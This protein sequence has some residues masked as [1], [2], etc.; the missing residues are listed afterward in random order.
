M[1]ADVARN[2]VLSR[3]VPVLEL[4]PQGPS[5]NASSVN[6]SQRSWGT[7]VGHQRGF[8]WL[9]TYANDCLTDTGFA[10]AE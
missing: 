3:D 6:R 5:T 10:V 2:A 1:P 9:C 7:S 8:T 4:P